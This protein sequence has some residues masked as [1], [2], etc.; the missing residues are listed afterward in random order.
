MDGYE[1]KDQ[2]NYLVAFVAVLLG[3]LIFKDTLSS[4]SILLFTWRLDWLALSLPFII[5]IVSATYFWALTM[6]AKRWPIAIP[7]AKILESISIIVATIGLLYPLAL[8]VSLLLSYL[9]TKIHINGR[10][11]TAYTSFILS[12]VTGALTVTSVR[13][14]QRLERENLS[15][16]LS[17]LDLQARMAQEE[18]TD[19]LATR[20]MRR[21]DYHVERAKV[22]LRLRGYGTG[23]Q[24]LGRL[25]Q[26]LRSRGVFQDED[27]QNAADITR[28]RNLYAHTSSRITKKDFRD[29][30]ARL[31]TLDDKMDHAFYA[32]SEKTDNNN[33][34]SK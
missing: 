6:L 7:L 5:A 16:Q 24:S 30:L 11:L 21:Y 15:V 29:A 3:L 34:S 31:K 14:A 4:H 2:F 8:L 20:F 12:I 28:L 25:A 22:Y 1:P 10:N 26:I 27:I 13:F 32:L 23:G 9:A 19:N 17:M 33:D 18:G